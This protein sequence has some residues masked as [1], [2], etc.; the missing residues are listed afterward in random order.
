MKKVAIVIFILVT[1]VLAAYAGQI[2]SRDLDQNYESSYDQDRIESLQ[3]ELQS[4][5]AKYEELNHIV[6]QLQQQIIANSPGGTAIESDVAQKTNQPFN[7]DSQVEPLESQE[8][9][10]ISSVAKGPEKQQYD[11]ALA[12]LKSNDLQIAAEKF[13]K[14]IQN[15]PNSQLLSNAL[16]WFGEVL[17]KQKTYDKAALNFL[18]SYKQAPKG[19]K[20]SD[21]LLRLATSLSELGKVTD[22]CGMLNKLENEFPKRPV[23]SLQKAES[24]KTKLKCK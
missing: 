17:F 13:R 16:F 8:K 18:K 23:A 19:A 5:S 2:K 12:A 1:T 10:K 20:A 9:Q 11:I 6:K 21:S 7:S 3:K 22:A 14:F 15:N 4:L 24:L